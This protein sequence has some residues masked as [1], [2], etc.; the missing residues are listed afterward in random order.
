MGIYCVCKAKVVYGVAFHTGVEAFYIL[1]LS[2]I[3]QGHFYTCCSF[4]IEPREC[5]SQD[6]FFSKSVYYIKMVRLEIHSPCGLAVR[7]I[8][9][10]QEVRK[11]FVVYYN[12]ESGA[13]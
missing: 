7:E 4:V 13:I 2:E 12:S 6:I 1:L 9:L 3:N 10:R 5:I 8:S 11:R